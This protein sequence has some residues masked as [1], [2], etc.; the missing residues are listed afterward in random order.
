[1]VYGSWYASFLHT[2]T[3]AKDVNWCCNIEVTLRKS[4]KDCLF[5]WWNIT[6]QCPSVPFTFNVPLLK[7]LCG[8]SPNFQHRFILRGS[9]L[10]CCLAKMLPWQHFKILVFKGFMLFMSLILGTN[11]HQIFSIG[12]PLECVHLFNFWWLTGN[13]CHGNIFFKF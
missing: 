11:F 3:R 13:C 6:N 10:Y 2:L 5:V 7:A 12:L 8:F 1:M 4:L 9:T